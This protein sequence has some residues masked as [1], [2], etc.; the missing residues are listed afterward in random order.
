MTYDPQGQEAYHNDRELKHGICITMLIRTVIRVAASLPMPVQT[1]PPI[2]NPAQVPIAAQV[3]AAVQEDLDD[4][5]EMWNMYLD[6]IKVDD[7]W[8]T[9][10]WKED[11]SSIV[12]FVSLLSNHSYSSH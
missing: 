3:P 11:A 9:D 7:N 5:S 10:A 4:D 2:P 1:A 8:T 6:E 12:V